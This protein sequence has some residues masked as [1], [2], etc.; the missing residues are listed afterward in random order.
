[1]EGRI[2]RGKNAMPDPLEADNQ[3]PGMSDSAR[4]AKPIMPP[5]PSDDEAVE[6]ALAPAASEVKTMSAR[7]AI[8]RSWEGAMGLGLDGF[9]AWTSLWHTWAQGCQELSQST[10]NATQQATEMTARISPQMFGIGATLVA[11]ATMP[12][13][14]RSGEA[15]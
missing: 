14:D 10:I 1:M 7:Q 9:A 3:M 2:D 6:P 11:R 15:R 13:M 5:P 8:M 12:V 4:K